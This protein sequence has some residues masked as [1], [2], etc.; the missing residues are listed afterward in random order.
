MISK[1]DS[2]IIY[3]SQCMEGILLR[4]NQLSPTCANST[5][6]FP[7]FNTIYPIIFLQ[8]ITM[9]LCRGKL[10]IFFRIFDF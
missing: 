3:L 5:S 2:D 4:Q 6:I 8:N 1:E 7:K 10:E 9:K